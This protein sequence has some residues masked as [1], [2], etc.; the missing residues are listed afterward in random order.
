MDTEHPDST[1]QMATENL[2]STRQSPGW[3]ERV[4]A[5]LQAPS[6]PG[7][8]IAFSVPL[9]SEEKRSLSFAWFLVPGQS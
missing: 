3:R 1:I 4:M 2:R 7:H 5:L 9:G 6:D 8:N